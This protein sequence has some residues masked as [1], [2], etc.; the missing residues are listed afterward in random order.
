MKRLQIIALL[1]FFVLFTS[2]LAFGG[3]SGKN[4][5]YSENGNLISEKTETIKVEDDFYFVHITDTHVLN[6]KFDFNEKSVKRFKGVL[7]YVCSF[8]VKPAFIVI[9]GDLTEW[10]G[11]GISGAL[12]CQAFISCL[13]KKDGQL[14]AD[15]NF[16]IPVYTTP[17]NHDYC[18]NRNLKNYHKYIDKNHIQDEDR[19]VV[20]YGDTSLFFMDTGP[21]YYSNISILF[22]WH[23]E[24]LS[25]CDINWLQKELS[26]CQSTHKIILMHHPAVGK[27]NDLF[28]NNRE[29]FVE[30]CET[31]N[32][33][34]VL[35]GHTHRSR[36]YDHDLNEY[37][38]MPLNCSQYP[39]L[40]VQTDDCKEDVHYRNISVLSDDIWL[41]DCVKL[42]V[43][44]ANYY[45]S[46]IHLNLASKQFGSTIKI[47][48]FISCYKK[49][50]V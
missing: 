12:N 50:D 23:G 41:D 43:S 18:F 10:G 19:Y 46:K 8:S 22:D 11:S 20:T 16:S 32:V 28:I 13:Y 42:E 15:V 49:T 1:M 17:G 48:K 38:E 24:G 2:S 5:I 30:L 14:Y 26:N 44:S 37:T 45:S 6:K 3:L 35:A 40:Y 39:T 27:K 29:E 9:T 7:D 21:N 34:V 33:E 25:D 47:M 4:P 36:V 31:Y